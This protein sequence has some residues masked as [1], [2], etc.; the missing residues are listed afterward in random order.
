MVCVFLGMAGI[1]P[2]LIRG[3]RLGLESY[4]W[5]CWFLYLAQEVLCV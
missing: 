4:L 3:S 1:I 2:F 5:G